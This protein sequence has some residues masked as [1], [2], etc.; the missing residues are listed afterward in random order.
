MPQFEPLGGHCPALGQF[1]DT[2]GEAKEPFTQC[3]RSV[4]NWAERDHPDAISNEYPVR[5]VSHGAFRAEGT[6][7]TVAAGAARD[8]F[9]RSFRAKNTPVPHRGESNDE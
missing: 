7:K 2:A 5:D 1:T 4:F 9:P 3:R 6:A 8:S